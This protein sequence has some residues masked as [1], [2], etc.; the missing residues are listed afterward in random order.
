MTGTMTGAAL[1]YQHCP[2]CGAVWYFVRPFCPRCGMEGPKTRVSSGRGRVHA[3]ATV[4]RAPLPELRALAPYRIAL[5]DMEEG[6][7]AMMHVGEE[8]GIGDPVQAWSAPFGAE[9]VPRA[10]RVPQAERAP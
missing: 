5:V 3:V 1:Q 6:F 9:Q 10:E 2:A 7:R 8:A 4:S